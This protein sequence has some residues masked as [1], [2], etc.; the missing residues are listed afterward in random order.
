[1]KNVLFV[2]FAVFY[3]ATSFSQEIQAID[4]TSVTVDSL[5]REDQF[6]ASFGFNLLLNRPKGVK[7]SGFSGGL[8]FGFTR[9]MPINKRRNKA[10]GLG[11][12]LSINSYGF[13]LKIDEKEESTSFSVIED[14]YDTNRLT[15]YLIEMPLEYRWRTS[16]A[17][18]YKFWRIYTGL[19]LGYV[20]WS[21]ANY[22]A[23]DVKIRDKNLNAL[24]N[25]RYGLTFTFGYNTFNFHVYYSLNPFFDGTLDNSVEELGLN[26][27]KIGIMFY[28]L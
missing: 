18:D 28:I 24:D 7:Q 15:H 11:L 21:K 8:H 22:V 14:S 25:I 5:Y 20:F 23:G 27:L 10:I 26:P 3:F 2:C 9:D 6:Y 19:R 16:T 13:N 12:G 17:S 1:M 4:T